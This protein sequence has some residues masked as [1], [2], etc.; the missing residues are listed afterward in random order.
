VST[1][2]STQL[3]RPNLV[4]YEAV[5]DI[6]RSKALEADV[7]ISVAAI[8]NHF[9]ISRPPVQRSLTRLVEEGELQIGTS[10]KYVR[11]ARRTVSSPP[12]VLSIE[13]IL[14][15]VPDALLREAQ[16]RSSW[17][18]L[19]MDVERAIVSVLPFGSYKLIESS[20]ADYY[21]VSRTVSNQVLL[22]LEARGFIMRGP[23][24]RWRVEQVTQRQLIDIY[25]L[26][27]LLEPAALLESAPSL[28]QEFI[29]AALLR[30]DEADRAGGDL[31]PDELQRLEH[32]LHVSCLANCLNK[33]LIAVI[34]HSQV[35]QI[36]AMKAPNASIDEAHRT[37]YIR[38]HRLV[39]NA[40]AGRAHNTAAEALTYHLQRS[41]ARASRW[42]DVAEHV[43]APEAP[44]FLL[45][46]VRAR[47]HQP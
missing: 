13:T 1:K 23:K 12:R 3:R 27:R 46:D 31:H 4:V 21:G 24:G 18:K 14:A 16:E 25:Q 15:D 29:S 45:P 44:P 8:A 39:F 38:E 26:R 20:L 17:Q 9:K 43:S 34:E 19:Y 32:D 42:L 5:K 36:A 41:E 47:P 40:L 28:T 22:L 11:P 37:E 30:L 2:A 6:L 7:N 35:L 33:R 10:G